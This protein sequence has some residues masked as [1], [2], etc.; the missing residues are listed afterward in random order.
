MLQSMRSL[1]K[2]I[3]WFLFITFVGGF[4]FY[5]TSG[6]TTS[7]VTR[8]TPAGSINGEKITLD[9][10]QR[11]LQQRL[12]EYQRNRDQ[13]LTLDEQRRHGLDSRR[14]SVEEFRGD[15]VGPFV[16]RSIGRFRTVVLDGH[17]IAR[18]TRRE[19]E[20]D[21]D[22]GFRVVRRQGAGSSRCDRRPTANA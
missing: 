5:E 19:P 22:R 16:Q 9:V 15:A 10:W 6:L 20:A 21:R 13:G 4:I 7:V 17:G 2:Y 18:S 11:T 1:A 14:V 12:E 3:F 8:G